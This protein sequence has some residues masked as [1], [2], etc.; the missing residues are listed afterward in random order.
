MP[1]LGNNVLFER[2]KAA[3][4]RHSDGFGINKLPWLLFLCIL[5]AGVLLYFYIEKQN[6]LTRLR[7]QIPVLSKEIHTL[8]ES[9]T[10]LS[11]EIELFESPEHLLQLSRRSEFSHLKHPLLKE[12]ISLSQGIALQ[13]SSSSQ[14]RDTQHRSKITFAAS[15]SH[16]Q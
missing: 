3:G 8:K 14:E 4:L 6:E 16:F 12:I 15:D 2:K 13:I 9:N 11:Y 10:R 7:L 5:C 1:N